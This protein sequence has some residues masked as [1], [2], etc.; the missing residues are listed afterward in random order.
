M[1]ASPEPIFEWIAGQHEACFRLMAALPRR[2][3]RP[4]SASPH[5]RLPLK[6]SL[7]WANPLDDYGYVGTLDVAEISVVW[8]CSSSGMLTRCSTDR[9]ACVL[10]AYACKQG[11]LATSFISLR[12]P[13]NR[14][15][16][17]KG[18]DGARMRFIS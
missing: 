15:R 17:R 9:R 12:R 2:I 16:A 7:V 14:R 18:G 4:S 11:R 1:L 3:Q 6:F 10:S 13:N 8:G 5:C